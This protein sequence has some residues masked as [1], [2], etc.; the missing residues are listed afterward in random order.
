MDRKKRIKGII[1]GIAVAAAVASSALFCGCFG[2]GS[3]NGVNGKDL[4]IYDLYEAAKAESG[5]SSLTMDE[6]LRDYLSYTSSE[7]EEATS[8][9]AA[10]NRSLMSAVSIVANFRTGLMQSSSG[11]GSGVIVDIDRDKGNMT[12]LTN[13][14]VVYNARAKNYGNQGYSTDISVWLYGTESQYVSVNSRNAISA[15]I[16]AASK[17]YDVALL[18]IENSD[19]VKSSKAIAANWTAEE[20]VYLGETVFA[21]GNANS[22]KISANVG[23][24]SRDV[25]QIKVDLG[26]KA[27][28]SLGISADP[29]EYSYN[30]IRTSAHI[31]GGNSGGG[32]FDINGE[33]VGLVNARSSSSHDDVS[34]G[35]I[36]ISVG[37]ALTSSSTKRV[38]ARML[39]DY[40]GTETHGVKRARHGIDVLVSDMYST[41]LNDKGYAEIYEQVE[42]SSVAFGTPAFGKLKSGDIINNV[43]VIRGGVTVENVQIKRE[44]NFHDV[45]LAVNPG[46]TVEISATRNGTPLSPVSVTFGNANFETKQ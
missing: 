7:L 13:C 40:S 28:A 39:A 8:I 16:I 5:N 20:D 33:L 36:D 18:K 10:V 31:Y 21:V 45:M 30:V 43:K 4:N 3:K 17:T 35:S 37:Y 34:S 2:S 41:G 32:L 27:D 11:A 44:H 22:D 25:E 9:K 6:F 46:D 14:H 19:L 42:V 24:I 23:Y 12:V 1:A 29:E 15:S 26:I 38:V